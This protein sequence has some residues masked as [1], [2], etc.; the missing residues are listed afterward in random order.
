M[1]HDAAG[2]DCRAVGNGPARQDDDACAYEDV[3]ANLDLVR[4]HG[5]LLAC[6]ASRVVVLTVD[7]QDLDVGTDDRPLADLDSGGVHYAA[8]RANVDVVLDGNVVS[9]DRVSRCDP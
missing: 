1:V 7:G 8:A 9:W 4:L 2:A 5:A 3:L 6:V